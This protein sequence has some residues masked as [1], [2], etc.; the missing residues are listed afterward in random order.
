[1]NKPYKTKNYDVQDFTLIQEK[2]KSQISYL[3]KNVL[4]FQVIK[5]K[6]PQ[7]LNGCVV[8]LGHIIM[9][10]VAG[11][12]PREFKWCSLLLSWF[13]LYPNDLGNYEHIMIINDWGP[14]T[15]FSGR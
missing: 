14:Q 6:L 7:R 10:F 3:N 12:L 8:V 1:M 9:I 11:L 2:P 5:E 13:E 4:L 15:N